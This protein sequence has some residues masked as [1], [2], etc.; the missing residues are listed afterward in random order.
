V[1]HKSGN[2]LDD[3]IPKV[4][5]VIT[6]YFWNLVF[7][8]SVCHLCYIHG[9]NT[10]DNDAPL[11]TASAAPIT[12]LTATAA[13]GIAN[14]NINDIYANSESSS[15]STGPELPSESP[16]LGVANITLATIRPANRTL[17]L[18]VADYANLVQSYDIAR[19]NVMLH[20]HELQYRQ[21]KHR[22]ILLTLESCH[23][24]TIASNYTAMGGDGRRRRRSF[25]QT[26]RCRNAAKKLYKK[27]NLPSGTL[28]L[29]LSKRERQAEFIRGKKTPIS[30]KRTAAIVRTVMMPKLRYGLFG[31]ALYEGS[32]HALAWMS[33]QPPPPLTPTNWTL[34]N[35][36]Q[37]AHQDPSWWYWA[38][39]HGTGGRAWSTRAS[40]VWWW[41]LGGTCLI[42][43]SISYISS[44][45]AVFL[46]TSSIHIQPVATSRFTVTLADNAESFLTPD[47]KS[48]MVTGLPVSL[49]PED[50]FTIR[51]FQM[52]CG[53]AVAVIVHCCW[54]LAVNLM[55]DYVDAQQ[56]PMSLSHLATLVVSV[57]CCSWTVTSGEAFAEDILRRLKHRYHCEAT[58]SLYVRPLKC[59][60]CRTSLDGWRDGPLLAMTGPQQSAAL[61]GS[62]AYRAF[63]CPK[64]TNDGN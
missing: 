56:L 44:F 32:V 7:L 25:D 4:M 9:H 36:T 29:F 15:S 27:W 16:R 10:S 46:P 45:R 60:K 51:C 62:T 31:L 17:G 54:E 20:Q 39:N 58:T 33:G 49:R 24:L 57:A 48:L 47:G 26:L 19:I 43:A 13:N 23:D 14:N 55:M 30:D 50:R 35:E 3:I 12:S 11:L 21:H 22:M 1:T 5:N 37:M 63:S 40:N 61:A 8:I 38:S 18:Y 2:L 34:V 41:V 42:L 28:M 53:C 59:M 52:A 64:C 6:H